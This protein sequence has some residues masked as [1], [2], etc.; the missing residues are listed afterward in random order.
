MAKPIILAVETD[1]PV[2]D[3]LARDLPRRFGA[4][5]TVIVERSPVTGLGRLRA[6]E[7]Q[8]AEG[9]G[10]EGV[11]AEGA[12][13]EVALLIA[14]LRMS[15]MPG[16]Q[17]FVQAHPLVPDAKRLLLIAHG[18]PEVRGRGAPAAAMALGQFE[19]FV[20]KP[21][22]SP[23]EWLY[24]AVGELLSEWAKSHLPR[25]EVVRVVGPQ[26]SA[27][28]HW[29]RDLLAR[30]PVSYGFYPDDSPAGQRLLTE[31]H[32][33]TSQLPAAI[34]HDGRVLPR[35]SPVELAAAVGAHVQAQPRLHDIAIVG[36]GP[37]G[38]AAAVYGASEGLATVALEA[39]AIGGQAGT[40]AM[41]R[42]YLGVARGISGHDLAVRAL[43]QA[44]LAGAD[45]VL[46][47]TVAGLRAEGDR[48]VLTCADGSEVTSRTVVI[49]TGVSYR[50]LG[51]PQE[52]A[53]LGRGVYYGGAVTEAPAMRGRRVYV[54][55]A[56]NSAGQAAIHL[57][58]SAEQVTLLVRGE[59]LEKSM[60]A[61][62]VK[63]VVG[64]PNIAV[65]LGT[66]VV[67]VH[68]A[69]RLEGLDLRSLATGA[70]ETVE[71][72]PADG[73]FAL[74]G[75]NPHTEWLASTLLRDEHGFL[76]TGHDLLGA[77]GKPPAGWH[78]PRPP[79]YL[80]TS[81]PGVLAA[82][83]ARSGSMKRVAAA[84]GEGATAISLIHRYL[85]SHD[86]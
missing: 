71:T 24:P 86:A 3:A 30:N 70:T 19:M 32:V 5:Y 41:I 51:I 44:L 64:T 11:G 15:E 58:K 37:A 12:G 26:W 27:Y 25:F 53:L 1:Q 50:R 84:V 29:M 21:W 6:I 81:V 4:D 69:Q 23:E 16:I 47:N 38:L 20:P 2:A 35:P 28:T 31:A 57:A 65:R 34:L 18:D 83:D 8:G 39:E 66:Q 72:V 36:A 48:H 74:I 13:A 61:Y 80:E 45:I 52:D 22:A 46:M 59:A 63:E 79:Y 49:A 9:V 68:G 77:E 73:L 85:A 42:N 43:Q 10:A 14:G 75:A 62:L 33:D 7:R 78:L 55:G 56:G 54:A 82:G 76:L 60:S 67:Q 17:F 40:S